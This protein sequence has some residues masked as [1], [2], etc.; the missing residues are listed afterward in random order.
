MTAIALGFSD[1]LIHQ[2]AA[3]EA[4][5]AANHPPRVWSFYLHEAEIRE[6]A[7]DRV[8]LRARIEECIETLGLASLREM[9]EHP[10]FDD[11]G[12]LL[13]SFA[14]ALEQW[15]RWESNPHAR[16][17]AADFKSASLR[18]KIIDEQDLHLETDVCAPLCAH[19]ETPARPLRNDTPNELLCCWERMGQHDRSMLLELARRL[20]SGSGS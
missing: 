12:D 5:I 14:M 1:S 11:D 2:K 7:S 6:L 18:P 13:A 16:C 4:N 19:F 9:Y 15:P 10:R 8:R 20:A 17:R 3:S